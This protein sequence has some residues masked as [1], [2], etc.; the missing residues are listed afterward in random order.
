MAV[1]GQFHASA[2]LLQGKDPPGTHAVG[3]WMGPRSGLGVLEK[4]K[5]LF[6]P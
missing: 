5:L 3:S 1:S 6:L 4:R 2:A